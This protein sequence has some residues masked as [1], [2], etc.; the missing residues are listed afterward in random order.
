[1]PYKIAKIKDHQNTG[2][3]I[4]TMPVLIRLSE[5]FSASTWK[6][7][8]GWAK[9]KN[10]YQLR[11]IQNSGKRIADFSVTNHDVEKFLARLESN[12]V[13]E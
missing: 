1:M 3:G 12:I 10:L 7:E 13:D 4:I 11:I 2:S 6:I 8:C 9:E 5:C